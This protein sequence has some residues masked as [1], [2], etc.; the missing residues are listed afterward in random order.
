MYNLGLTLLKCVLDDKHF[1][2]QVKHQEEV[3]MKERFAV[4]FI[5]LIS[6]LLP[7]SVFASDN[8]YS[9]RLWGQASPFISGSAGSG[10]GAP[11]YDDAFNSGIGIGG[12][13]DWRFSQRISLLAGIGYETYNGSSHQGIS[14]ED[15]EI[16]PVYAGGKFHITPKTTRW[17]PYLRMDIGAA[18]LSSVDVSYQNIKGRYWD[19]SWVFLFGF[20]G[21]V[22]YRWG[23]WG[24]SLEGKFRYMGEPDSAMGFPSTAGSSWTVP[25][26]VGINYHF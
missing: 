19:S 21:G 6:V 18:H 3:K 15:I 12:E 7:L 22:E 23:R 13:F 17:D 26:V 4:S 24:V 8:D 20:G 10:S 14:F 5:I 25:I 2:H 1:K 16:V 9:L 11:D